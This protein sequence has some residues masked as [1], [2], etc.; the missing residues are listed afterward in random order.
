MELF[1]KILCLVTTCVTLY[2]GASQ[3]TCFGKLPQ[4]ADEDINNSFIKG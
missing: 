1:F 2:L 3:L 4:I